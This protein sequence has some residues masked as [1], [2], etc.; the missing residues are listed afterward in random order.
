MLPVH[1]LGA[2]PADAADERAFGCL[3]GRVGVGVALE[4]LEAFGRHPSGLVTCKTRAP[5]IV[6]DTCSQAR[7]LGS[8]C[9]STQL[10]AAERSAGVVSR[11]SSCCGSAAAANCSSWSETLPM[12]EQ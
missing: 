7:T 5:S 4:L 10:C 3:A 9:F 2:A 11:S 6:T 8:S 1:T 12:A